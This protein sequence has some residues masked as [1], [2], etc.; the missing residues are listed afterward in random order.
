MRL[1]ICDPIAGASM[2]A[3]MNIFAEFRTVVLDALGQLQDEGA[4]PKDLDLAAVAVQPPK[5]AAHG[6]LATNAAMA[7][8]KAAGEKPRDI[9]EK[10]AVALDR[11]PRVVSAEVAGPGFLNLR[12]AES[13]WRDVIANDRDAWRNATTTLAELLLERAPTRQI[14]ELL[15]K[16]VLTRVLENDALLAW[17]LAVRHRRKKDDASA[18]EMLRFA[19]SSTDSGEIDTGPSCPSIHASLP[20]RLAW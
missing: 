11:D 19:A 8:A 12:L 5:D 1:D 9:A 10:L 14:V 20:S 2:K 15:G 18:D 13:V 17:L 7:L 16:G 6:D 3:G 4:L